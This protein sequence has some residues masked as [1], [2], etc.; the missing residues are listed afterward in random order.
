MLGKMAPLS[1]TLLLLQCLRSFTAFLKYREQRKDRDLSVMCQSVFRQ[2]ANFT[3]KPLV[4]E[5]STQAIDC[6]G[7]H[8]NENIHQN[9]ANLAVGKLTLLEKTYRN[10]QQAKCCKPTVP[11]SLV[12]T[13]HMCTT[14]YST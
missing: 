1:F 11:R 13:A 4:W 14:H 5:K 7:T 8:K 6:T 3:D 2:M 9:T 10:T 12:K